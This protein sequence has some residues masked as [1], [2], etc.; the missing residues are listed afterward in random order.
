MADTFFIDRATNIQ[1]SWLN[2]VNNFVYHTVA[3]LDSLGIIG[4]GTTDNTA[5]FSQLSNFNGIIDGLGKT[6]VVGVLTFTGKIVL[7]NIT[8]KAASSVIG[9]NLITVAGDD[10]HIEVSVDANGKGIGGVEASGNRITGSVRV[11]NVVGQLQ[12]T[13]GTQGALKVSGSDC[14]MFV[15]A[16]NLT[17]G[18]STNTSIPRLVTT[19]NTNASATR[20]TI[21]AIGKNVQCGWVTTQDE[22]HCQMLVIDGVMDNGIYHLQGRATAGTVRIRDGH[23]EPVV[24]KGRLHIDDLT[25]IDTNGFSSMSGGDL[26]IGT[27]Q[28]ISNDPTKAYRPLTVRADNTTS[29]ASIGRLAGNLYLT[30]DTT[31]GGIFQ[32]TAG[33]VSHLDIGEIDL[34]VHYGSGSTKILSNMNVVEGI[35]IGKIAIELIDDTGTLTNADKLD[36]RLPTALTRMSYIGEVLNVSSSGDVRITNPIQNL[37]QLGTSME[38]SDTFGP[39]ILQENTTNPC[40]RITY[41]TGVPTVGTWL[42]GDIIILKAPFISGVS[43]YVCTTGGSPGT[44]RASKWVTGRG[45]T[46][47][48]PSLTANDTGVTYLDNTIN[49]N[50]TLITWNGSAWVDATG[51][52]V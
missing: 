43:E 4:D 7:R 3:N 30:T 39:Y 28:V 16:E 38:V 20:N 51:A 9:G 32:F 6:Y 40:P 11:S 22:V 5:A 17:I 2:D 15:Y 13:G 14:D 34:E 18:T 8:F 10:S 29:K 41:G 31:I 49:A 24:C 45:I 52:V 48:R 47:S 50:G 46:A 1:S 19:D 37:L 36:F 23:D 12:A 35:N 25:V 21:R 42:R 33:V 27:Y 26:S 44:W